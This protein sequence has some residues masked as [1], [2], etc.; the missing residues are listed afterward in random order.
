MNKDIA[1]IRLMAKS[2]QHKFY[3][4]RLENRLKSKDLTFGGYT[5]VAAQLT[6][7]YAKYK[8]YDIG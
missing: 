3:D 5:S 4:T 2:V 6:S 1:N 7:G 8:Y